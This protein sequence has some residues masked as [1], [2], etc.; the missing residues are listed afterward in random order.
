MSM[1]RVLSIIVLFSFGTLQ[2]SERLHWVLLPMPGAFNLVDGSVRDG[3]G[4]DLLHALE[5]YLQAQ[6]VTVTYGLSMLPRLQVDLQAGRN[7]C[8]T[9]VLQTPE[10]DKIGYFVPLWPIPPRQLV[11]REEH[12]SRL[13]VRD[14]A[15]DAAALLASPLRGAVQAGRVYPPALVE[16]LVRGREQGRL[17]EV[18]VGGTPDNHLL[19]LSY[20]RF[21]YLLEYPIV[22]VEL[23][24][25]KELV[26][27]LHLIPLRGLDDLEMAGAYCTRNAWGKAMA[28]QI[29]KALHQQLRQPDI[30]QIYER[31]LPPSSYGVYAQ[32]ILD[33]HRQRA[34]APASP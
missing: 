19:M 8:V 13:P 11:V 10:R 33:S 21:D 30:M 32:R 14:G 17:T 6:G 5:P 22:V 12:L 27:P 24:R 7:I 16:L 2:A 18:A 9:A 23:M 3:L 26:A 25:Q 29:A 31:W 1:L 34:E 15:V 20:G 4:F 28:G